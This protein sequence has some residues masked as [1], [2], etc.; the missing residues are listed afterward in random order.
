MIRA[1][2][3]GL[4]EEGRSSFMTQ[5]EQKT[6]YEQGF[7]PAVVELLGASAADWPPD[8]E[9]EMFRARG[10]NGQLSFITKSLPEWCVQNLGD[11]I[12]ENLRDN[13]IAWGEGMVFLHQIRGVKNTSQ[14]GLP[15]VYGELAL[16]EWLSENYLELHEL[17]DAEGPWF[18]DVGLEISSD[19]K[20]CLA[21]RTDS[22]FHVVEKLIKTPPHHARR[23]TSIGSTKYTRD[24]TSHLTSVSGCRIEPGSRAQ[25]PFKV[26]YLQLYTTDKSLTYRQEMGHHGKFITCTEV[27]KGKWEDYCSNLYAVYLA[28]IEDSYSL[29]RAEVRVPLEHATNVLVDLDAQAI[30]GWLVSFPRVVWWFVFNSTSTCFS[31][32]NNL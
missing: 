30:R 1:L 14:H 31:R 8:Y 11:R 15:R 4:H 3:P 24:M 7:R 19:R 29:A 28:A 9:S 5:A 21:W 16:E 6:F 13:G 18:T 17:L 23:I 2:F 27:L 12:R 26:K 25:G 10:H 32:Q 22:H 20:D